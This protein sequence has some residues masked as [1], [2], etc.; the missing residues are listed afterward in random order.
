MLIASYKS[1]RPGLVGV[2]NKLIQYRLESEISHSELVFEPS[3]GVD[4]LMPDLT[5]NPDP[6]GGLWCGSSVFAERLPEFSP[7]RPNE[8]GGVRFKRINV[9]NGNWTTLKINI[10]RQDKI[11]AALW[12]KKHQGS[13]YDYSLIANYVLWLLPSNVDGRYMC[14]ESVASALKMIEAHRYDPALLHNTLAYM[15]SQ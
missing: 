12:F 3:D 6:L 11:D 7:V 9:H 5:T 14:S 1:V 2:G 10:P 13:Y 4:S 15:F 8:I